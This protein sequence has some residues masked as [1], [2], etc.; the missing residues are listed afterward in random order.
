LSTRGINVFQGKLWSKSKSNRFETWYFQDMEFQV[1]CRERLCKSTET[2]FGYS[3]VCKSSSQACS[4]LKNRSRAHSQK[5]QVNIFSARPGIIIGRKGDEV[6]RLKQELSKRTPHDVVINIKEI[7]RPEIDATL[8]AENIAS[9]LERRIAYRRAV[10]RS[11]QAAMRMNIAGCKVMVGGRL[12]GAEIA[13]SEW[14][15]EGQ[16]RLHTLRVDID[17]GV[18]EAN[19]TYGIIG[20]KVWVYRGEDY[21]KSRGRRSQS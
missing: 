18:A 10:K 9:Q 13:R 2:G 14:V 1:V 7:K 20:V 3:K 5:N 11:I 12:N 4:N 19:T 15:R 6:E 8:I 17:Y 16:V 21:G